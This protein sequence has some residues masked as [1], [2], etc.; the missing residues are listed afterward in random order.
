MSCHNNTLTAETIAAARQLSL[1]VDEEIATRQR[2]TIAGFLETW[3]ERALQGIGIPGDADTVS[4]I[5]LGLAAEGHP[6]DRATDAM[7]QFLLDRQGAEGQWFLLAHRPPIESSVIEVTASSMRALQIYGGRHGAASTRAIQ[8]G[9][10]M[11]RQR[12]RRVERGSRVP[13]DG[14]DVGGARDGDVA[15]IATGDAIAAAVRDLK[16][17]QRPDGGWAQTSSLASDAYA[18]GQALVALAAS[19]LVPKDDAARRRGTDFLLNTQL[20]DGSW[21]VRTRAL[22]IQPYFEADFPHGRNQFIS[23]AATNW[24][25][26]ALLLDL[27]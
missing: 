19:G 20:A 23:A 3:R 13:R 17:A 11:D 27:K 18:T 16:A 26:R 24:A 9:R 1:K 6:A 4:Y 15:R 14:I 10:R 2:R 7:A 22:P 8:P 21:F 25:A 5:L 12:E